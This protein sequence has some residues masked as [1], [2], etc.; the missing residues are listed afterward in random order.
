V[1]VCDR[2]LLVVLRFACLSLPRTPLKLS[3]PAQVLPPLAPTPSLTPLHEIESLTKSKATRAKRRSNPKHA[4]C[5]APGCLNTNVRNLTK[6][7]KCTI[8]GTIRITDHHPSANEQWSRRRASQ[9]NKEALPGGP[10]AG[11][12][13][14]C[15]AHV[16]LDG[17][18][19]GAAS[20]G[21]PRV[22][23]EE[24]SAQ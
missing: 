9:S 23:R 4:K 13:G 12:A 22:G 14:L 18:G 16:L 8:S 2:A 10:G 3:P 7:C 5:N 1:C 6:S 19:G 11:R 15:G 17:C 21:P 20:A 24:V